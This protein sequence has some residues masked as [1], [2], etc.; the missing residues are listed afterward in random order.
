MS[1]PPV[2]ISNQ[3]L[4]IPKPSTRLRKPS[5]SWLQPA[6]FLDRPRPLL[7]GAGKKAGDDSRMTMAMSAEDFV[8]PTAF[9]AACRF[10]YSFTSFKQLSK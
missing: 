6:T 7:A 2:A 10:S 8:L 3:L 4:A 1:S 5:S 9:F